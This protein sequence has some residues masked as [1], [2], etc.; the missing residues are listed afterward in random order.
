MSTNKRRTSLSFGERLMFLAG[1]MFCLIL[2]TTAMMGG[3]FARYASTGEGGDAA[4]V[5]AFDV[6]VDAPEKVQVVYGL[7][8]NK[9]DY[10]L[11]VKNNSEVAV[12][13]RVKV[14]IETI[15]FGITVKLNEKEL[16]NVQEGQAGFLQELDFGSV[17]QLA[18]GQE[19]NYKLTFHVTNWGEFT[20]MEKTA[21]RE[22][23]VAFDVLIDV[24]QID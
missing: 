12:D 17:G 3:L 20:K 10:T 8:E 19:D 16:E 22:E 11:M 5:A 14:K 18:P 21:K 7:H 1:S 13:C 23:T 6:K 4:R 2:I 9:G 15:E 24:V